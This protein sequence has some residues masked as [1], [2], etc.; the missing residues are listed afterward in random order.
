MPEAMKDALRSRINQ[1]GC[2]DLRCRGEE[3]TWN[4]NWLLH[5]T[6]L[7][8]LVDDIVLVKSLDINTKRGGVAAAPNKD[9]A[10]LSKR[11]RVVVAASQLLD[12]ESLE[13]LD[14]CWLRDDATGLA[15][16]ILDTGLTIVVETPGPDLTLVI[17]SE[18]VV[19]PAVDEGNRPTFKAKLAWNETA[20]AGT[21]NDSATKLVLLTTAPGEDIVLVVSCHNVVGSACDINDL[22]ELFDK[23]RSVLDLDTLGKPENTL[24]GL[25]QS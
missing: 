24:S 22:L 11:N 4:L 21:L 23:E 10:L 20:G 7:A 14:N 12:A 6:M 2:L 9:I 19:C 8:I 17:D 13:S 5:K 1:Y 15:D 18:A 3:L 25:N 16:G